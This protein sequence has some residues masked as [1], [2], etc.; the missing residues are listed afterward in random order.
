MEYEK[1]IFIC[2]DSLEGI[3]T[4]IYDGWHWGAKGLPIEIVT[5]EPEY[6]EFS[7]PVCIF[8]RTE[9]AHKV[10]RSV[11]RKLG[12][13]VYEAVCY[14]AVSVHQG[15]G[16]AIFRVL[17]RALG[18]GRCDRDVMEALTDPDVNLVFRLRTKVWHEHHRYLGFVRFRDVGGGVL[19]FQ[20]Y[21][22]K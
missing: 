9:K 21:A 2:D 12:Y 14:A 22:G 20:D 1:K 5:K 15:K 19:F 7:V 16:T 8:L 4:G 10:A 11:R 6:P 17:L 3:F 18:G 13:E